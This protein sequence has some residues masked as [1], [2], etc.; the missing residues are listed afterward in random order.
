[1]NH[2]Q[3]VQPT[4]GTEGGAEKTKVRDALKLIGLNHKAIVDSM[5]QPSIFH[6]ARGRFVEN[7]SRARI[8]PT[9]INF[10][11]VY[12]PS[13]SYQTAKWPLPMSSSFI[14]GELLSTSIFSLSPSGSVFERFYNGANWVYVRHEL[15]G[16]RRLIAVTAVASHGTI[17]VSDERG[18]LFQ[19][20][21][22]GLDRPLAWK[23]VLPGHSIETGG[24]TGSDMRHGVRVFFVDS[25][26]KIVAYSVHRRN[27]T[28]YE[29]NGDE[30]ID[31][32]S[33]E[34][35]LWVSDLMEAETL[36]NKVA[37]ENG[38]SVKT[39]TD[40]DDGYGDDDDDEFYMTAFPVVM[41][42]AFSLLTGSLF[43][44]DKYGQLIEHARSERLWINHGHPSE[45]VPLSFGRGVVVRDVHPNRVGSIFLRGTDGNLYERWWDAS[46][47]S[48]RW[49]DHGHPE[50]TFVASAPGALHESRE[51]YVV[52]GDAHLWS[53]A[54]MD[55]SW[56]WVDRGMPSSPLSVVAPIKVGGHSVMVMTLDGKLASLKAD[57]HVKHQNVGWH[58]FE[59][60]EPVSKGA[61]PLGRY[62]SDDRRSPWNCIQAGNPANDQDQIETGRF[63]SRAER[64]AIME[65]RK[66][67]VDGG[68][69]VLYMSLGAFGVKLDDFSFFFDRDGNLDIGGNRDLNVGTVKKNQK[70]NS[71]MPSDWLKLNQYDGDK[72]QRSA[73]DTFW[74]WEISLY[75]LIVL[76]VYSLHY[77]NVPLVNIKL[78]FKCVFEIKKCQCS[79]TRVRKRR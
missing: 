71:N 43:A 31:C 27:S 29:G 77:G 54:F 61:P 21:S 47:G 67:P 37:S 64:T 76:V 42:D 73:Q 8:L 40:D 46:I 14:M 23:R 16:P 57:S 72:R 65:S 9:P 7:V 52:G 56:T 48:W 12:M 4:D 13:D 49:M 5:N 32:E 78:P 6:D 70:T 53:R 45:G 11:D 68:T 74:I 58:E 33:N 75:V 26:H 34:G 15:P 19:R 69:D 10:T 39:A 22:P 35:Q 30:L 24:V 18:Q 59:G 25:S 3:I 50:N 62:C 41:T 28:I 36:Q 55:G 20:I 79:V 51:M 60:P 1:M 17:F 63:S 38:G 66:M 2:H 44:I